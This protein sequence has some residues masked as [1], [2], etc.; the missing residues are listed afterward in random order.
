M[1]EV[2][3]KYL[4]LP[5]KTEPP[6]TIFEHSNDVLQVMLYLLQGNQVEQPDLL[7]LAALLHDVGKIEQKFDGQRWVH[8]PY[9]QVNL[10]A[11]L[12]DARFKRMVAQIGIDLEHF[13]R[14]VLHAEFAKAYDF[15]GYACE[16][17][18]APACSPSKL[19]RCKPIILV[20]VADMIASAVE[21]GYVGRMDTL[22]QASPYGQSVYNLLDSLVNED[23]LE[24]LLDSLS[25]E[26]HRI[27]FPAQ[28][29]EDELLVTA[30]FKTFEE[31]TAKEQ[32]IF[33]L[34]QRGQTLWVAGE[35]K[36]V[37]NALRRLT[38]SPGNLYR[39]LYGENIYATILSHLP[40][41]GA[42]Q[43][44]SEKFILVSE[45]I[46]RQYAAR[47]M[48]RRSAQQLVERHNISADK[49]SE[50]MTGRGLGVPARLRAL[51]GRIPYCL[52]GRTAA[53]FYSDWR[54]T[55]EKLFEIA[56]S[57]AEKPKAYAYLKNPRT[58]VSDSLGTSRDFEGYDEIVV[59]DPRS[60]VV[61]L[62]VREIDGLKVLA[63]EALLIELIEAS[64]EIFISEAVA[65]LVAQRGALDWALIAE[66][67]A[68]RKL[69]RPGGGLCEV[70]NTEAGSEVVP[71]SFIQ[72]LFARVSVTPDEKPYPF[73]LHARALTPTGKTQRKNK[74]MPTTQVA[75]RMAASSQVTAIAARWGLEW[76]LPGPAIRKVLADL[77]LIHE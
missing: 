17:H 61:S 1:N 36:T 51:G 71:V 43:I 3:E 60:D 57:P 45:E 47:L 14:S 68:L 76:R 35:K 65:L 23:G 9:T 18:H 26:V 5:G 10:D 44:D 70:I 33:P 67:L 22:L 48:L 21:K 62:P 72:E 25:R 52:T 74:L 46:A 41:A 20:A 4:T 69:I 15:L 49:I 73:P 38:L 2:F 54:Y 56:I 58:Y 55:P 50:I 28:F 37:E 75:E 53:Y 7:K 29:V 8:T 42:M 16:S 39:L 6:L 13:N 64:E 34:L 59:L 40:A 30:I 12:D 19:N 31:E 32:A 66:Q 27:E 11:L 77:G 24:N 63:P